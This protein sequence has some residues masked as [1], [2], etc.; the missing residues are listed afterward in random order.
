MVDEFTQYEALALML[1]PSKD[2]LNGGGGGP[3]LASFGI[4]RARGITARKTKVAKVIISGA[5]V[6]PT[7]R[8][9]VDSFE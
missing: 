4:A 7:D 3:A 8:N 6:K 1:P 9:F 5:A 2:V